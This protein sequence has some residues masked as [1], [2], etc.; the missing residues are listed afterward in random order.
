[1]SLPG[2][3]LPV[4]ILIFARGVSRGATGF[5]IIN[6]VIAEIVSV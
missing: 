3:D 2:V 6:T 1:M 5:I 4:P